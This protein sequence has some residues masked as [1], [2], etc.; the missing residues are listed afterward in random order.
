MVE[1]SE[2]QK[3]LEAWDS[4]SLEEIRKIPMQDVGINTIRQFAMSDIDDFKRQYFDNCARFV[5]AQSLRDNI[6]STA[7]G[8]ALRPILPD[9]DFCDSY[10]AAAKNDWVQRLNGWGVT[11]GYFT[12]YK[13]HKHLWYLDEPKEQSLNNNSTMI[14][15]GAQDLT[16]QS[17]IKKGKPVF[18]NNIR[19]RRTDLKT[20]SIEDIT[21]IRTTKENMVV[22]STPVMFKKND[23]ASIDFHLAD[24]AEGSVTNIAL[25]GLVCEAIGQNIA[26]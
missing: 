14:I 1:K 18:V 23:K 4:T 15:F 6:A 16:P 5:V 22:F 25:L 24:N 13:N 2:K 19:F 3:L 9:I 12:V 10:D 20:I 17:V 11:D 26:G 7:G 21:H 8:L